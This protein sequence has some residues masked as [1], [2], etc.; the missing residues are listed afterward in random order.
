ME[1]HITLNLLQLAVPHSCGFPIL[2]DSVI[3][4]LTYMLFIPFQKSPQSFANNLQASA[5]VLYLFSLALQF[6]RHLLNWTLVLDIVK[7]WTKSYFPWASHVKCAGGAVSCA[8]LQYLFQPGT[9]LSLPDFFS[10]CLLLCKR[11]LA[12][13]LYTF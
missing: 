8:I 1:P 3:H 12:I 7:S 10:K 4:L 2:S 9:T 5:S 6:L 13:C 11:A